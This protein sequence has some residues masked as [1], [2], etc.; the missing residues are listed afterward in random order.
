MNSAYRTF[1][2]SHIASAIHS[3]RAASTIP[4]SGSK[5][6]IREILIR[7]LFRPLLPADIGV[8]T[9]HIVTAK[10]DKS[11]QQDV[12]VYNRQILPPI[13]HENTLGLF[14]I[15]SVLATVE[16]KSRLT[17]QELRS[18]YD[19][20]KIIHDYSYVSGD[21]DVKTRNPILHDVEKLISTK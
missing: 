6:T 2:V 7:E 20:A 9:G 19:N 3:A 17:L 12:I 16:V 18:T 4:H 8:G 14:P 21:E 13:L 1:F 15:E 5:G 11:P 10:N